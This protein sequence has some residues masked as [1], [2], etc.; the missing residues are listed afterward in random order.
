MNKKI[1]I[2]DG[3]KYIYSSDWIYSLENLS[4]WNYYWYQQKI[5]QDKIKKGDTILEIGVGSGF[6]SNYLKSKGFNVRTFDIDKDKNPDI[7]GNLVNYDF[8]TAFDHILAFE[9]FE[10]IPYDKFII[11]LKKLKKNCIKTL[12]FSVPLNRK[13]LFKISLFL[14]YIKDI[15]WEISIKKRQI[16]TEAHYWELDYKDLSEKKFISDIESTGYKI[17]NSSKFSSLKFYVLRP[18]N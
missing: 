1:E 17:I 5:L 6:T 12:F 18:V 16:T 8:K 10:H 7:I 4:L 3:T 9:I 15:N 11:V 14:P 13:L 2:L